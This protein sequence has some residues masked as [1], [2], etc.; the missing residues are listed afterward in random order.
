MPQ[1]R[2]APHIET[3]DVPPAE[4][5]EE[6]PAGGAVTVVAAKILE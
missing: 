3:A 1:G 2:D 6:A 5:Y 4:V